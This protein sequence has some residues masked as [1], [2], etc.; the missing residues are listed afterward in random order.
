MEAADKIM[1]M[2]R[3][4]INQIGWE[5]LK[6]HDIVYSMMVRGGATHQEMIT[7][8]HKQSGIMLCLI[9]VLKGV[10]FT[11]EEM[12][13][14]RDLMEELSKTPKLPK[15]TLKRLQTLIRNQP[16]DKS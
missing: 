1:E 13:K 12:E 3:E 4:E 15:M 9:F 2:I 8:S 6:V 11:D 7:P 10:K 16:G 14:A 5:Y